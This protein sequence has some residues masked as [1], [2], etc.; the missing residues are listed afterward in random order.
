MQ[1]NDIAFEIIMDGGDKK[2]T[3]YAGGVVD[4]LN[5]SAII[6]NYIPD[7]LRDRDAKKK[8]PMAEGH[9][10]GFQVAKAENGSFVLSEYDIHKDE[11]IRYACLD[12]DALYEQMRAWVERQIAGHKQ[13]QA[14]T[15]AKVRVDAGVHLAAARDLSA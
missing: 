9:S 13:Y 10:L 12:A 2:I 6:I 8:K 5:E 1:D 3:A 11:M 15:E 7:L 4:G 14:I